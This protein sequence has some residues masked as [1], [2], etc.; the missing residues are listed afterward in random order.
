MQSEWFWVGLVGAVALASVWRV[1]RRPLWSGV[2]V[3]SLVVF[4]VGARAWLK[5]RDAD[6]PNATWAAAKLPE[7]GRP[8]FATS[9]RCVSCHPGPHASWHRSFHRTM[10]QVA[11]PATSPAA[12]DD[13]HLE[14]D[15]R[16]FD[17][18]R[19]GDALSVE[20]DVPRASRDGTRPV[21]EERRFSMVTG[22]HHMQAFWLEDP[23]GNRQVSF[24]FTWLLA[25]R[26]WV[27]RNDVFLMP[28]DAPQ[29]SQVW[30]DNCIRCHAVGGLPDAGSAGH[31]LRTQVA[32][33]GIA[34]EAC[35]GP[36][37]KH[38]AAN[39]S[40]LRRYLQHNR[41]GGDPTIVNP[42]RLDHRR[43][44]ETCGAC[45]GVTWL[46]DTAAWHRTGFSFVPGGELERD[47]LL[48]RYPG[49]KHDTRFPASLREGA[50][51]LLATFWRDGDVR[52]SGREFNGLVE[53]PC[54]Q[55]GQMS[56]LSC[57]S[58][59]DSEPDDQLSRKGTGDEACLQCHPK[60]AR[61]LPAHTHHAV[62][63]SG[64]RCY[65]CHMPHT[66]FGLMKAIRSH[67]VTSP[68]VRSDLD[69][70]RPNACN[71]CHLDR[72]LA[73]TAAR[74]HDWFRQPL[75]AAAELGVHATAG[76]GP[77]YALSG[78][79]AQRALVAWHLGW[80]PSRAA[81]APGWQPPLLAEL[82]DDPY[83][84]VRHIAGESLRAQPGFEDL[85]S[86]YLAPAAVRKS[87]RNEVLRRWQTS[88]PSVPPDP[89]AVLLDARGGLDRARSDALR[90][91]RDDR[92]VMLVE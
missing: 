88:P 38:V 82:L 18:R 58:M 7:T 24:P 80:G 62:G 55:R 26:R 83:S 28:P 68:S 92:P 69:S 39:A 52:V 73:W 48:V 53:S 14:L 59:H 37:E 85:T 81:S 79:A 33:L 57:H 34:C 72:P 66:T 9:D 74:L 32:E 22:S 86:D 61:D 30:N 40:P 12:F 6:R 84:V 71:L 41:S 21:R 70:G 43:S 13:V 20:L 3:A 63:S 25:E 44:S 11:S 8:G 46:P 87:R 75:P 91:Q 27:P 65:N 2:L 89:A 51:E 49:I 54:Y 47:R 35:H 29:L 77:V 31:G 1:P 4:A 90:G 16:S 19:R 5:R 76:A 45:H 15:G 17:L 36:G 67:R 10:T 23:S 60:L 78:D 56:C 50:D 64:S 42:A